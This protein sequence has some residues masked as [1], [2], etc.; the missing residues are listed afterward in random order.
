MNATLEPAIQVQERCLLTMRDLSI[1]M[2]VSPRT[3]KLWSA[4]GRLDP[5]RVELPGRLM[6]YDK[7][8]VMDSIKSGRFACEAA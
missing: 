7:E 5:F 8:K 1:I 2:N 6:R 4:E 3:I